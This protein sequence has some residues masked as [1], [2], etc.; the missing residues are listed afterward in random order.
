[1]QCYLAPYIWCKLSIIN[2]EINA[3]TTPSK[4][5]ILDKKLKRQKNASYL[6]LMPNYHFFSANKVQI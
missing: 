3:V 1:M 5:A 4:G 6:I 2:Q